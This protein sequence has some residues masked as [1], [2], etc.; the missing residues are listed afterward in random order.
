MSARVMVVDDIMPNVKLLEAKLNSEYYDV[1]TAES[2]PEALE[3]LE[4]DQPD[5]ILLDVMM[6]GMDGFEVCRRIKDNPAMSHIPIV[7]VTAL[8]DKEDRVRGLEAGA[9]DFL[10]KP[11]NDTAL[12]ARVRSL[13]RLKMTVDEW[14]TRENTARQLGVSDNAENVM[15]Q[16]VDNAKV[17]IVEDQDFEIEKFSQTLKVDNDQV[18]FVPN[19]VEALKKI[20]EQ[21][22]DILVVSLNLEN[23]DGLRLS[24]H[25][26][27]NEKTRAVPILMISYE[28][29][30]EKVAR[31][32]EMGAHDY[33]LRPVDRNEFLARVRTQIRRKRYQDRLRSNY[34]SSLT[35]AIRDPLT[36][37]YNRRYMET[38]MSKLLENQEENRKP[39]GVLL[40]DIDH[41]KQVNDTYGHGV[42]DEVL[43]EFSRRLDDNL[44]GFDLVARLGGEEFVA[45][46]PDVGEEK[47]HFIAERLRNSICEEPFNIPGSDLSLNI[48]SSLGGII[49]QRGGHLTHSVL[50]RADKCLYAAK[51]H[52]RNC[53]IFERGGLL[54]PEE[55]KEIPRSMVE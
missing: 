41:F 4:H 48:S 15:L 3:K 31:G 16:P 54:N 22:F 7:M 5:L 6:P 25:L 44:R 27:S 17:L 46:L 39:M 45:I 42:G 49:V 37:L 10:S 1:I 52:G 13:V 30:M 28:D 14:R 36:G 47:A 2:G 8:T 24:S 33:V 19:G 32:L 20:S 43:K 51:E 38:H 26:R 11:I 9:D 40:L 23:E 18:Y 29:E 35:M 34:E 53:T 21:D 12:M 55:Y 50:E